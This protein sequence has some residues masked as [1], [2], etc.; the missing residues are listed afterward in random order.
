MICKRFFLSQVDPFCN[1]MEQTTERICQP[2]PRHRSNGCRRSTVELEQVQL[3]LHG[4]STVAYTGDNQQA[5]SV[6]RE[7]NTDLPPEQ[8][9]STH[10]KTH[11]NEQYTAVENNC[12]SR[13]VDTRIRGNNF[14][15]KSLPVESSRVDLLTRKSHNEEFYKKGTLAAAQLQRKSSLKRYQLIW[16]SFQDWCC[17][18]SDRNHTECMQ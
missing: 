1:E 17:K 15:H 11:G 12:E 4:P 3:N 16:K 7:S 2:L 6:H 5:L 9:S 10:S 14:P 8:T 18:R 13:H